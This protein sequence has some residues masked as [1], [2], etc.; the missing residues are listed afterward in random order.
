MKRPALAIGIVV[1]VFVIIFGS[2]SW[3][4][5]PRS[6][7]ASTEPP[8]Q[9]SDVSN[10]T[11]QP[12]PKSTEKLTLLGNP[13]SGYSTFR[14]SDFKEALAKDGLNFTYE[15]EYDKELNWF[16]KTN[17]ERI[18]DMEIK[19][20][21]IISNLENI[22]NKILIYLLPGSP[23]ET[24]CIHKAQNT[25]ICYLRWDDSNVFIRLPKT[26]VRRKQN[27]LKSEVQQT[28]MQNQGIFRIHPNLN[29]TKQQLLEKI[30]TKFP[31]E[32]AIMQKLEITCFGST[33]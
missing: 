27:A 22:Q 8:S 29:I 7:D 15:H 19:N 14:N 4:A 17:E 3:F 18:R 12:P 20:R 5:K 30:S 23:E 6:P 9:P 24:F 25:S 26:E 31:N 10:E 32:T 13:F 1:V 21:I 11:P 28:N 33:S 16:E 2:L